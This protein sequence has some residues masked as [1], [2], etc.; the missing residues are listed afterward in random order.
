MDVKETL[1]IIVNACDD[2]QAKDIVVLDMNN[3]S[4]V[5]DY[6]LICHASNPRQTQAI[7]MA[8]KDTAEENGIHVNQLEGYEHGQ[9]IIVDTEYVLCHIF[10][11]KE[12]SFYNLE[13]LWGD[14]ERVSLQIGSEE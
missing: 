12:R 11:E 4:L 3:V 9:W 10:L 7:A 2:K 8:V 5:A 14:A 13:R 1:Q 6:F